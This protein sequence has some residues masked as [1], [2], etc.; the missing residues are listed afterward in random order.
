MSEDF[1]IEIYLPEAYNSGNKE[2]PVLYLTDGL[3][4]LTE[5]N[6][7]RI[8]AIVVAVGD[9]LDGPR[10][11][12]FKV[13]C[14]GNTTNYY[15][16]ISDE[17]VSHVD[18]LYDNNKSR[19]LIGYSAGGTFVLHAL[20][21]ENP[22]NLIFNNYIIVDPGFSCNSTELATLFEAFN[23]KSNS[24]DVAIKLF[25]TRSGDNSSIWLNDLL[26][27]RSAKYS[28]LSFSHKVFLDETHQTV[29]GPSFYD[30]L[31]Y[32]FGIVF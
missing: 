4:L 31:S 2:L 26:I 12:D 14:N 1:P 23:E 18:S 8:D 17:L 19:S 3:H 20:F 21:Q 22:S 28:W 27:E 9:K 6:L 5:M 29:V 13:N 24:S 32:I 25:R 7:L 16:F 15:K 11:K 10:S 30:G